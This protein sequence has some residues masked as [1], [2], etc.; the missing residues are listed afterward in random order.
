MTIRLLGQAQPCHG[1]T[2]HT[3]PTVKVYPPTRLSFR[4]CSGRSGNYGSMWMNRCAVGL[5]GGGGQKSRCWQA[6]RAKF[7]TIHR[8]MALSL[9]RGEPGERVIILLSDAPPINSPTWQLYLMEVLS[10][11]EKFTNKDRASQHVH[12]CCKSDTYF[13]I[14]RC[15]LRSKAAKR[16]ECLG[17]ACE[18]L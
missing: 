10:N 1:V 5:C 17:T 14:R 16:P 6:G 15:L 4:T 7:R 9:C 11:T 13:Y 12:E 8:M 2:T 18:T 3:G